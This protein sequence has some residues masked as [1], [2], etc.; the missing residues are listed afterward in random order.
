MSPRDQAINFTLQEEQLFID[1]YDMVFLDLDYLKNVIYLKEDGSSLSDNA[2]TRKMRILA[3]NGYIKSMPLAKQDQPGRS[4]LVYTLDS[5]GVE[6]SREFL[7]DAK[8]DSRWTYRTPSH[9]YHILQM[10]MVRA[11]YQKGEVT[12]IVFQE[13]LSERRSF[14]NMVRDIMR[15]SGPMVPWF[16]SE[17]YPIVLF[18]LLT[19]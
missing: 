14:S 11:A 2:I 17:I 12:D 5:R 6:E 3:K 1:L 9:I 4:K 13:W 19:F 16:S 18:I 8:W 15:S 10:A 7:G